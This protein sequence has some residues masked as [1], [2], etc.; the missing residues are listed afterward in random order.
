MFIFSCCILSRWLFSLLHLLLSSLPC[1]LSSAISL[2]ISSSLRVPLS[3][4]FI[5][6]RSISS[7]LMSLSTVSSSSGTLSISILRCAIASSIKSIALSGRK[8][9]LMY[10][11]ESCTAE[12]MA[13]SF[14]L[15]LWWFSYLSFSPRRIDIALA[16]SGSSTITCWKRLSSALSF[17]K[18]FWYS[19]K[20]VAPMDLNSPLASAGLS[21]LAASMAP[22][23]FPAPTSVCI[24]SMNRIISPLLL[25]TSLTTD[26]SLSSNSPLYLAP[27][28]SAP[29]SSEKIL[30]VLRFSGT[31]P[32]T[33]LWARPSAIAVFP[34]PGSPMSIGLFFVLRLRI[35]S[36]RLISSS[37]PMTGSSLPLLA[38]SF[39]SIAYFSNER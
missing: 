21:M 12:I 20:V 26:F 37:R 17:S 30:F 15:T 34:V 11:L 31:S 27:A 7:C 32:L 5:A 38:F 1:S 18:Y 36:T 29:M 2:F 3:S 16:S 28:M 13:S 8:R 9:S 25:I 4:L 22:S 35:C 14:I 10:R 19:S 33:I 23:L 6:S 24:S 39:R